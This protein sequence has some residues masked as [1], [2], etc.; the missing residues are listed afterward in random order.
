MR[1][2]VDAMGGDHGPAE[3]VPGA[4]EA[5]RRFGLDVLLVGRE[6]E[7]RPRLP[8]PLPDG[9][10]VLDA[11]SVIQDDESPTDALRLKPD[12]SLAQGL[13]A[14]AEGEGD[15]LV[16]AGN[17]GALVAGAVLRFGLFDGMRRPAL[18]AILPTRRRQPVLLVDAGGS[19]DS[20]PE[21]L[22]DSAV[23]GSLY[24]AEVLGFHDPK[25]A[26]LNIGTEPQKGNRLARSAY[27]LLV[28]APVR[29]VGNLEA[30][31]LLSGD[32]HVAVTDGFVGNIVLKLAEGFGSMV[33][34]LLR[35]EFQ[36]TLWTRL[37]GGLMQQRLRRLRATLDY[38]TYGGA[39]LLGP[40]APIIKCH[41]SS[42]A[43]AIMNGVRV[44]HE[45]AA[46]RVI[47]HMA[48]RLHDL[49]VQ[50]RV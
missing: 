36:A 30:R 42:R 40:R 22:V 9:V 3:T 13:R 31:D 17:T 47:E 4:L 48:D 28:K 49:Q 20:H 18:A 29:F 39:P 8:H 33:F 16:S 1:V 2:V 34:A 26:L 43:R 35:E 7:I 23:L 6:D 46:S 37:A 12:S 44:A 41:G 15:V 5:V 38:D 45:F 50:A 24:A 21:Q 32:I 27:A 14:L 19:V 25:V 11:P 10:A